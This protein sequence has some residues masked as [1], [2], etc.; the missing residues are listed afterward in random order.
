MQYLKLPVREIQAFVALDKKSPNDD[1]A[2]S[3]SP[4]LP[5]Y[6]G[7]LARPNVERRGHK[8]RRPQS[9]LCERRF[10]LLHTP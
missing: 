10:P 5:G 9:E 1:I 8:T 2:H 4:I 7:P 6:T 3:D